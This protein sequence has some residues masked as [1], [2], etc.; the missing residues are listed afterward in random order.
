MILPPPSRRRAPGEPAHRACHMRLIGKTAFERNRRQGIARAHDSGPSGTRPYLQTKAGGAN[1]ISETEAP[2]RSLARNTIAP[3]P[4]GDCNVGGRNDGSVQS[5]Y[6]M[7][8]RNRHWRCVRRY[9]DQF[10]LRGLEIVRRQ[11][12]QGIGIVRFIARAKRAIG[13]P[14][15]LHP[16]G[17][18]WPGAQ[19]AC[20]ERRPDRNHAALEPLTPAIAAEKQA[21]VDHQQGAGSR[22]AAARKPS[23]GAQSMDSKRRGLTEQRLRC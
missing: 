23:I 14:W 9:P 7:E 6:P 5:V 4:I 3:R 8:I 12:H 19:G 15:Q 21:A 20:I 16:G 11:Q 22:A 10:G 18:P 1:I 2:C 13:D 17:A